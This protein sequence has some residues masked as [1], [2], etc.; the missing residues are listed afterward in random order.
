MRNPTKEEND[1]LD[2]ALARSSKLV[3]SGLLV[4]IRGQREKKKAARISRILDIQ[5]EQLDG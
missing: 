2:K 4:D 5:A 3:S 1:A